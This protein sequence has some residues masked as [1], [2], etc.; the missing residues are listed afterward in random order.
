MAEK[1]KAGFH[2]AARRRIVGPKTELETLPGYWIKPRKYSSQGAA[3]IQAAGMAS[4]DLPDDIIAKIGALV[5]E[6]GTENVENMQVM[7]LLSPAD[8]IRA[9]RAMA[10]SAEEN[11][12][13]QRL[14]LHY[15]IG[16]HNLYEGE[17]SSVEVDDG[18]VAEIMEYQEV[19]TEIVR[20]IN[21]WNRPLAVA[22][23]GKSST[24]P[25]GPSE[26]RPSTVE[27]S[28]PTEPDQPTCSSGGG[29]G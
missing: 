18:L 29:L 23:E 28:T 6:A 11:V 1:K 8:R 15:G 19:A 9:M 22:P 3:E 27:R 4:A 5:E 25:N 12:E 14:T 26:E 16:E 24:Q 10:K 2:D 17:E 13:S 7:K 20:I 21:E